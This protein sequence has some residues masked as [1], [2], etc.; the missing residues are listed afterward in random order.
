M[1]SEMCIRDRAY[2]PRGLVLG[3]V[4][5]AA[6]TALP[7]ALLRG[8]P[9]LASPFALPRADYGTLW[10]LVLAH[11]ITGI[12]VRDALRARDE[13]R[14]RRA[15]AVQSQVQ[16]L[17]L[18]LLAWEVGPHLP[19]VS[20]GALFGMMIGWA[21]QDAL[22][23]HGDRWVRAQ[24]V[25]AFALFNAGLLVRDAI[26][27]AGLR[28]AF[29]VDV[30]Y[31]ASFLAAQ[32]I[33]LGLTQTLIV[34]VGDLLAARERD[35][36]A[37]DALVVEK[38]RL[39]VEH[40]L[41]RRVAGILAGGVSAGQLTH[42][43]A[44]PVTVLH[45]RAE[46]LL[47][48]VDTPSSLDHAEVREHAFEMRRAAEVL[49]RMSDATMETIRSGGE[50]RPVDASTLIREAT[51]L[52]ERMIRAHERESLPVD[53]QVEDGRVQVSPL[54][55]HALANLM[56]NGALHQDAT[57][58]LQLRGAVEDGWYCLRVRDHGLVESER[59]QRLAS[60]R[61]SLSLLHDA[62]PGDRSRSYR[63]YGMG[64]QLARTL[65]LAS[66]GMFD[67]EEPDAGRGVIAVMR[68]PL[69]GR[70]VTFATTDPPPAA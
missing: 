67:F 15:F 56:V 38:Q 59:P 42:D 26:G 6:L 66:G 13:R 14:F 32:V 3:L 49:R 5:P 58:K 65:V 53:A 54:H 27:G 8:V 30:R 11:P 69:E 55:A 33:L 24:Y 29:S 34:T 68:L 36:Q 61:G 9:T 40:R 10:A 18:L 62:A 2:T 19:L 22:L 64:L 41:L 31:A 48:A 16:L 51:T 7:F 23:S 70:E 20:M 21:F 17:W 57:V 44:S 50:I 52:A 46:L 35:R 45:L 37:R 63:G 4:V 39:A 25:I 47:G 28:Y 12:Q 43:I 60:L 1:G